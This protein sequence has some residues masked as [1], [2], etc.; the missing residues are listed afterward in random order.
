MRRKDATTWVFR[1]AIPRY[2]FPSR[3]SGMIEFIAGWI[4]GLKSPDIAA[5]VY[6][7]FPD[8]V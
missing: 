1:K 6:C 2:L 3:D 5:G 4:W 8:A 7:L